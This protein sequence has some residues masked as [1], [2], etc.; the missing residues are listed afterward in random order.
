MGSHVFSECDLHERGKGIRRKRIATYDFLSRCFVERG[1]W[2]SE[3]FLQ[4]PREEGAVRFELFFPEIH[5]VI[6][7]AR[8]GEKERDSHRRFGAANAI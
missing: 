8:K 3:E 2:K 6:L 1:I 7:R 5:L 4:N